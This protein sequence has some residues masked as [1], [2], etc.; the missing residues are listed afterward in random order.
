VIFEK[1]SNFSLHCIFKDYGTI[2]AEML[3]MH[4]VGYNC[5]TRNR[6]RKTERYNMLLYHLD[7][8]N[9]FRAMYF[10]PTKRV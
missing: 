3:Q 2:F 4:F 6:S 10:W 1:L 8:Q 7:L 9:L 5:A